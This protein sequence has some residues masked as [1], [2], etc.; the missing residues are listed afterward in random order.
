MTY[1]IVYIFEI[2]HIESNAGLKAGNNTY[3]NFHFTKFE[4]WMSGK[5]THYLWWSLF[6]A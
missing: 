1:N 6:P 4:F 3:D 2:F 5:G